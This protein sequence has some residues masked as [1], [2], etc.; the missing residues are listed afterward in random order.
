MMLQLGY[1][2]LSI[3]M[4]AI[5]ILLGL[6]AISKTFGDRSIVRKKS[7]LLIASLIGWHLYVFILASTD[8]M[9]DLRFPPK[10]FIFTILPTFV[11][12]GIFLFKNRNNSWV[13]CIP[14]HWLF[15]YQSFRIGIEVLFVF[16][17]AKGILHPN[18]SIAGYNFDLI[19]AVTVLVIG[20][21]TFKHFDKYRHLIIWWN[22]L[23]LVFIAIIIFL[24]QSTIYIPEI[25]GDIEPFPIEF[26]KYP[27]ILVPSFLMP[28]AVFMHVLSLVQL[29]KISKYSGNNL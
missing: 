23:G 14:P 12:I 25:Y 2:G 20:L 8:F 1:I 27:Y 16:T 7:V 24:F 26:L 10:F 5:L 13:Q 17:V 19:Y 15:F 28:S 29:R 21:L 6:K 9:L 3:L 18:V 4:T 22:Y 11:F